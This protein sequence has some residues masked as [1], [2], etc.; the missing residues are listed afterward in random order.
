MKNDKNSFLLLALGIFSHTQIYWFGAMGISEL[1]VFLV[2]PFLFMKNYAILRREGFLTLIFLVWLS[3]AGCLISIW[4]NGIPFKDAIRGLMANYGL[5]AAIV[6][7]HSLLRNNL[8]GVKWFL[9]GVAISLVISTFVFQGASELYKYGEGQVGA[10]AS[11]GI[12]NSPLFWTARIGSFWILPCSGWYFSTPQFW[13]WFSMGA[14]GIVSIMISKGSGRSAALTMLA[15]G[16]LIF[17]CGKSQKKI[18]S[19]S[20]HMGRLVLIGVIFI[21]VFTTV[22][23][24]TAASGILGE[25]AQQKYERQVKG[26]KSPL[27]VLM[28]GRSEFFVGIY[29]CLRKPIFGYGPWPWDKEHLYEDWL[30]KYGTEEATEEYY[31]YLY[32]SLKRGWGERLHLIPS[33]SVIVQFWLWYGIAGLMLWMYV[34]YKFWRYIRYD[35]YAVPQCVGY[36]VGWLP[37]YV[38]NILFSPF[39]GRLEYGAFISAILLCAAVNKGIVRLPNEML[40][41]IDWHNRKG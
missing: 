9:L 36:I 33:H 34:L 19:V 30:N 26:A 17:L 6:V 15:S 1:I 22:Y 2:A 21:F 10:A 31:K 23:R 40:A 3:F 14:W 12:I 37:M 7:F 39:G 24:Y 16:L 32:D 4:I 11:E 18:L 13:N 29:A 20:R 35:M 8:M 27:A 28:S 41:E 38:W 5:F 25:E